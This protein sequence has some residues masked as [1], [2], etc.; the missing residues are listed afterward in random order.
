MDQKA[1]KVGGL[2]ELPLPLKDEDIWL[3]NNRAAAMKHL[4]FLKEVWKRWS[5]LQWIQEVYGRTGGERI[6]K[7]CDGKGPDGKTWYIPHQGVL[8]PN[9]GKIWVAFYCGSQYGETSINKSLL[10][11]PDLI[12][13]TARVLKRI[14]IEPVAFMADIQAMFYQVKVREKQR[15]FLRMLWWEGNLD[16]EIE[17]H[18]MCVHLFGAVSSPSSSNYALRKSSNC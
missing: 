3:P 14:K 13:Q 12:N 16:S 2:Y 8:N 9:K 17:D 15:S 4:E 1:V 5:I 7:K 6:C 10:Y 18:E 11:G